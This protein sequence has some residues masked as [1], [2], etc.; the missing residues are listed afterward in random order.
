MDYLVKRDNELIEPI[1]L[2]GILSTIY[3]P[4]VPSLKKME[5]FSYKK[6]KDNFEVRPFSDGS[7]ISGEVSSKLIKKL[8]EFG[9]S[10]EKRE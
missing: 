2:N 3:A 7:I 5:N 9:I 6:D 1:E 8:K 10:L 4:I